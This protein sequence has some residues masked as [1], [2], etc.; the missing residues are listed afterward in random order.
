MT[1][2]KR[3]DLNNFLA[4]C[5]G[6]ART[7]TFDTDDWYRF[8]AAITQAR[9]KARQGKPFYS[10]DHAGAVANRY[11]YLTETARWG[12]WSTPEGQV[13][14]LYDRIPISGRS[15][16]HP[17]HGGMASYLKAFKAAQ[18]FCN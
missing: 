1:V 2:R 12:V 17:Y 11:R 9:R 4:A 3:P 16:R 15:V 14:W 13:E 18:G 8:V 5:N 7:R 6:T 10:W